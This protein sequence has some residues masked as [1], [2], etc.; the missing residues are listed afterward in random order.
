MQLV[1]NLHIS[2]FNQ[3]TIA[4][5][6]DLQCVQTP[7][8]HF[9]VCAF[10]LLV[11]V[12]FLS[13]NHSSIQIISQVTLSMLEI[14]PAHS[15][16]FSSPTNDPYLSQSAHELFIFD[17]CQAQLRWAHIHS[18]NY[19]S[20]PFR[21]FLVTLLLKNSKNMGLLIMQFK[22]MICFLKWVELMWSWRSVWVLH[23]FYDALI[24]LLMVRET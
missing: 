8:T 17:S 23:P 7:T 20:Y 15:S 18:S 1:I 22:V 9:V 12:I 13:S 10:D 6:L 2:W 24:Q 19:Y 11:L 16:F 4:F 5:N 3:A 14:T 21:Q